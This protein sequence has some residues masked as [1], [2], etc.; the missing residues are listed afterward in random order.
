MHLTETFEIF[1]ETLKNIDQ[2]LSELCELL[3]IFRRCQLHAIC[4]KNTIPFSDEFLRFFKF[5]T[6]AVDRWSLQLRT[7]CTGKQN[8]GD[9]HHWFQHIYHW[10]EHYRFSP[11]WMDDQR[12][13][14]TMRFGMYWYKKYRANL[15]K[16]NTNSMITK[17]NLPHCIEFDKTNKKCI[18]NL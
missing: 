5:V 14:A 17:M 8:A 13:E 2:E 11:A 7:L 12:T 10:M 18:Y 3:F 16:I 6:V 9:K 15:N 4:H 1:V